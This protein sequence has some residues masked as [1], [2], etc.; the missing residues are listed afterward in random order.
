MCTRI[1]HTHRELILVLSSHTMLVPVTTPLRSQPQPEARLAVTVSKADEPTYQTSALPNFTQEALF[2]PETPA[3]E[4]LETAGFSITSS[5]SLAVCAELARGTSRS[6]S[7]SRCSRC[8]KHGPIPHQPCGRCWSLF[9]FF[10]V[11]LEHASA[12][13]FDL[14]PVSCLLCEKIRVDSRV[15][16]VLIG[17]QI[18]PACLFA[19][20]FRCV[21]LQGTLPWNQ[22]HLASIQPT[23]RTRFAS[24]SQTVT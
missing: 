6:T 21:P 12:L 17:Q 16:R 19:C 5:P 2:Y 7:I 24:N 15:H 20:C 18:K 11:L 10:L 13:L 8:N 14:L 4:R 9:C 1:T 22:P 3:R 23:R